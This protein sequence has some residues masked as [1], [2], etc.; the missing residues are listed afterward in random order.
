MHV[1]EKMS[2]VQLD[3]LFKAVCDGMEIL[4]EQHTVHEGHASI[5]FLAIACFMAERGITENLMFLAAWVADEQRLKGEQ[6]SPGSL[7]VH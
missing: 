1:P 5:L 3:A 4:H 2:D 6:V 7:L